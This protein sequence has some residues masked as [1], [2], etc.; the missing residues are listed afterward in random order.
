M[1][2]SITDP[3]LFKWYHDKKL[4]SMITVDV[5]IFYTQEQNYLTKHHLLMTETYLEGREG[6]CDFQYFGLNVGSV[7]FHFSQY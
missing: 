3:V 6:N 2:L 4:T 5:T 1:T 7:N